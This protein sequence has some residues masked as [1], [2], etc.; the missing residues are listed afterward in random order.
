MNQLLNVSRVFFSFQPVMSGRRCLDQTFTTMSTVSGTLQSS[1]TGD[2]HSLNRPSSRR[3]VNM[4]FYSKLRHKS[5][6]MKAGVPS[7]L[8][9]KKEN[10]FN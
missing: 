9:G 10:E 5:S 6:K 1:A 4:P 2:D 8:R 7:S 3:A